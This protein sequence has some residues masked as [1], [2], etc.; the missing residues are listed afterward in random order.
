M[1]RKKRFCL[2]GAINGKIDDYYDDDDDDVDGD[3]DN[4]DN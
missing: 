4:N 2:Q 3:D 1:Y